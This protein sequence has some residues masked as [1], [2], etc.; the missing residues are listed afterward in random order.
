MNNLKER[1]TCSVAAFAIASTMAACNPVEGATLPVE[2]TPIVTRVSTPTP[3]A[4]ITI[5]VSP[6]TEPTRDLEADRLARWQDKFW[7]IGGSVLASGGLELEDYG[8]EMQIFRNELTKVAE[9]HGF[10]ADLVELVLTGNNSMQVEK[11]GQLEQIAPTEYYGL[12]ITEDKVACFTKTTEGISVEQDCGWFEK[13][14]VI[15]GQDYS[16]QVVASPEGRALFSLLMK[17]EG[18]NM[19]MFRLKH[20]QL[21]V[22]TTL[23]EVTVDGEMR[24]DENGMWILDGDMVVAEDSEITSG[25]MVIGTNDDGKTGTFLLECQPVVLERDLKPE[26]VSGLVDYARGSVPVDM[27]QADGVRENVGYF[28]LSGGSWHG[29]EG[30]EDMKSI[31]VDEVGIV[32]EAGENGEVLIGEHFIGLPDER[33]VELLNLPE[34]ARKFACPMLVDDSSELIIY[35]KPDVDYADAI[36]IKGTVDNNVYQTTILGM[37]KTFLPGMVTLDLPGGYFIVANSPEKVNVSGNPLL[38]PE[39]GS[40]LMENVKPDEDGNNILIFA[41]NTETGKHKKATDG[42][43]MYNGRFVTRIP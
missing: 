39:F 25:V 41:A 13:S 36:Y 7:R 1:L 6:T 26:I 3:E 17:E 11:D 22:V 32:R 24:Q 30:Y 38:V 42:M 12:M 19:S 4:E 31:L 29:M 15:W 34:N 23:E 5:S 20:D 33:I 9:E 18:E 40:V 37:I 2:P 16:L 43:L 8:E 21:G 35:T 28:D 14:Q 27:T 10:E